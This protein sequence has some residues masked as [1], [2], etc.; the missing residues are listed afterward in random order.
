[1]S[2]IVGARARTLGIAQDDAS[3]WTLA[4]DAEINDDFEL[5]RLDHALQPVLPEHLGCDRGHLAEEYFQSVRIVHGQC[6]C[7]AGGDRCGA[8][9]NSRQVYLERGS[10]ARLA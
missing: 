8:L 7:H 10:A 6:E 2:R 5:D 9:V 3:A 4:A 1:M